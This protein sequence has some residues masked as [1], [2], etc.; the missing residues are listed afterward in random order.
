MEKLI[1]RSYW[2]EQIE[3][4]WQKRSILWLSG[5]RRTGKT[6]LSHSLDKVEY[7]DCELPK[8]RQMME[9][10]EDFLASLKGKRIALDEIHR[11]SNPAE[12]LKIAAD[13]YATVRILAT[14]SST[15]GASKKFRDT[16]TGRKL[17]L[18]LTP[19]ILKDLTDFKKENLRHRLLYG[20]LPVFFQSNSLPEKDFQEW[21]DAYWAKD[22]QELFRLERRYSFQKFTELLMAQSGGIFEATKFTSP[23]EVSRMTIANYLRA[24]EATLVVHVIRP[25]STHKAT[26]IISSPKVFAFDTGFVSYH[27]GW[28]ELHKEDLGYLWEHFVLNEIHAQTQ[29][30]E[31]HYWRN[32]SG[33]EVDFIL[34]KRSQPPIAIECKWSSSELDPSGLKAFRKIYPK[35]HNYIVTSDI[36]K[37]YIKHYGDLKTEFMSLQELIKKILE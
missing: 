32:K 22:I 36:E 4:S 19:M 3:N 27:K 12:L 33:H 9:S 29:S 13:H 28:S 34:A 2:V 10:P 35:G 15:I 30:H 5:V 21:M 23:C 26:E 6:S 1:K 31:V 16:L 17:E 20:G 14:G 37:A 7:F 25:Y 11:L 18:W 8:T 24:L